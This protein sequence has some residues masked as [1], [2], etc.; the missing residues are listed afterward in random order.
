ME[1]RLGAK[2]PYTTSA[3]TNTKRITNFVFMVVVMLLRV[4]LC[5]HNF[6]ISRFGQRLFTRTA[7]C[8]RQSQ[9]QKSHDKT[10]A[11]HVAKMV[12]KQVQQGFKCRQ[13]SNFQRVC[14]F[15]ANC[16]NSL[17]CRTPTIRA[18]SCRFWLKITVV[19]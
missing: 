19:G 17:A 4:S 3:G 6:A 9:N 18:C 14:Q 2:K 8:A 12:K 1:L 13:N 15:T 5:I 7:R 10:G 16:C 11:S